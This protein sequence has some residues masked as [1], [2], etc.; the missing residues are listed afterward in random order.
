MIMGQIRLIHEHYDSKP[1]RSLIVGLLIAILAGVNLI[2]DKDRSLADLVL[3]ALLVFPP[4][5]ILV[6]EL[7]RWNKPAMVVYNDRLEVRL[8]FKRNRKE[9]LYSEIK[10][11]ALESGQLRIWLDELSAPSCYNLGENTQNAEDTYNI[12]RAT[13]DKYNQEYGIRPVPVESMP[14]KKAGVAQVV[15]IVT[16]VCTLALLIIVRHFSH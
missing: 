4:F 7:L 2:A 8:P 16:M 9:I 15:L 3:S 14:Q 13:F 5:V 1:L 6:F 12:I 10:N 11:L